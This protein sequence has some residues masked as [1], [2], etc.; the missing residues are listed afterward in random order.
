MSKQ[1]AFARR[2]PAG[3]KPAATIRGGTFSRRDGCGSP[4]NDTFGSRKTTGANHDG[5]GRAPVART[6]HLIA[7]LLLSSLGCASSRGWIAAL[8]GGSSK[9]AAALESEPDTQV[10]SKASHTSR[11]RAESGA[12][13]G[14]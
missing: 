1:D 9:G 7:F 10:A 2:H 12:A 3:R 5:P 11:Y 4:A 14:T 13:T 8:S 6:K